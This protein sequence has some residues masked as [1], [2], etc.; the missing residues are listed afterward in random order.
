MKTQTYGYVRI[1]IKEQNVVW[2]SVVLAEYEITQ[3]KNSRYPL[4]NYALLDEFTFLRPHAKISLSII[5]WKD[6]R[7]ACPPQWSL[8]NEDRRLERE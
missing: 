5:S 8:R 7:T 2:Q 6:E 3:L 1:S 4:A